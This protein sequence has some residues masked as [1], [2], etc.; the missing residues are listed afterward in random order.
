MEVCW[1][2]GFVQLDGSIV[3][4]FLS[5]DISA[6]H[7]HGAIKQNVRSSAGRFAHLYYARNLKI[8]VIILIWYK[9]EQKQ[10]LLSQNP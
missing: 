9:L 7:W 10:Y 4:D 1:F 3:H 8:I 2:F 5:V 6:S